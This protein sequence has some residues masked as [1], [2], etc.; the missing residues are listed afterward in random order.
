MMDTFYFKMSKP[1]SGSFSSLNMLSAFERRIAS[2]VFVGQFPRLIRM[3]FGGKLSRSFKSAKSSSLVTIT[4]FF[5]FASSQIN[6]SDSSKAKENICCDSGKISFSEDVKTGD[7]CASKRSMKSGYKHFFVSVSGI[8]KAGKKIF[9]GQVRKVFQNFFVSHTG[10]HIF[11]YIVNSDSH[12]ANTGFAASHLRIKGNKFSVIDWFHSTNLARVK[13]KSIEKSALIFC[14]KYSGKCPN[15]QENKMNTNTFKISAA[16]LIMTAGIGCKYES[17]GNAPLGK[18]FFNVQRAFG[19][20]ISVSCDTD[21]PA[22]TTK[23]ISGKV[24]DVTA[25]SAVFN[26]RISTDPS[27]VTTTLTDEAGNFSI[28]GITSTVT[29]MTVGVT[30][31]GYDTFSDKIKLT[32]QNSVLTILI[33]KVEVSALGVNPTTLDSSKLDQSNI[34]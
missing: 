21:T 11:Q 25:L 6:S 17:G 28:P 2:I 24:K 22:I 33:S 23:K 19:S 13:S 14:K 29:D 32:C 27:V 8:S 12:S 5:S 1:M 31:T 18:A 30:A 7:K 10:C 34:Q 26:A 16:L 4:K 20:K 3:T 15:T 9:A